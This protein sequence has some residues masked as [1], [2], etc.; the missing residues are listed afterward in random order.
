MAC[1]P[2]SAMMAQAGL[3][4]TVPAGFKVSELYFL[5][6]VAGRHYGCILCPDASRI[7]RPH[8]VS[9]ALHWPLDHRSDHLLGGLA[10]L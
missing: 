9:H 6:P 2:G 10:S 7:L 8:W 5:S 1:A 3:R 4:P